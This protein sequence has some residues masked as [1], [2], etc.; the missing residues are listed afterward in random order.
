MARKTSKQETT[1]AVIVNEKELAASL[2]EN[3]MFTDL[4]SKLAEIGKMKGVIGYIIRNEN[5]AIIDLKKPEKL[6]EYAIFSSQVLDS[7]R[8]ISNLFEIGDVKNVLLEGKKDKAL[9]MNI[10]GNKISIFLE[11]DANNSGI[12]KK[13]SP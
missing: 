1:T 11:K 8:Q 7:T 2:E 3:Q 10:E 5:S 9:C 12:L 13:V 4:S 6:V